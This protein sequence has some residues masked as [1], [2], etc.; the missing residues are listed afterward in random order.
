MLTNAGPY[1]FPSR[2][3]QIY[4]G[5][6]WRTQ[7]GKRK[8]PSWGTRT[9]FCRAP[10]SAANTIVSGERGWSA[11]GAPVALIDNVG[12]PEHE[13]IET[14]F[15][16][17]R[18]THL[19]GVGVKETSYY[20][21][22]A[23]LLNT[24]G[25]KLKPRVRCIIH[26]HSIGAGLPD[27]AL[28]TTDQKSSAED[29]LADGLVPSRGVVEIKSPEADA[30]ATAN[31]EQVKKYVAKYGLVLVSNLREFII[32]GR[33]DGQPRQLEKFSIAES[34]SDFWKL[35]ASPKTLYDSIGVTFHEY[36]IRVL[37]HAAPLAAPREVAWFLA[38]YARDAKARI[39]TRADLPG[40]ASLRSA[41]EEALGLKFAGKDGEHFFR[42]SLVQT[43]FY[44]VFSAWVLWS[45]RPT[46]GPKNK[47][48]W[49]EAAWSLHVPMIRT[50]FDQLAT[51]TKLQSL[52]LEEV[53][54]WTQTA[55]NR[56]D[57]VAFFSNFEEHHA[58]QYFYEP[59]LAAYDPVLRKRLGVWFTPPEIVRYMVSRIDQV[60]RHDLDVH[61]GFADPNVFVLDPCCGTGAFLVEVL[62]HIE[63]SLKASGGDALT[64]ED[65]KTAAI[66]RVFGFELLPAPFVVSHLQLGLLLQT[67]GAPL[68]HKLNERVGVYLTNALTGWN[69]PQG[70]K[71]K[72]VFPEMEEERDA[73]ELVKREKTILVV[74]GNPPY[75][76]FAGVSP[77]EEQ[78][79][80]EPYKKGLS[81]EW[82]IKKYNLDELYVRFLRLGERRIANLTKKG[83]VCYISSYSYLSDPSFVVLR[84]RFCDEFD[85]IW[86]DCLNGDSR[87]TGKQT[88]DG[89]PD[90]SVFSTEY[91]REGIRLGTSVGLFA[92]KDS[93]GTAAV[94]YREFW[95]A[96]KRSLLLKTL[97]FAEDFDKQYKTVNPVPQNRFSFRPT[98]TEGHYAEWPTVVEFAEEE[99][100]SGL[101][102][103]RRGALM[104]HDR[105]VLEERMSRYYD[106]SLA[107]EAFAS[108]GSGL[109]SEAARFNA[110]ATRSKVLKTETFQNDQ[111]RRYTLFPLDG[112]WCYYSTIRPLWNEPRPELVSQAPKGEPFFVVR[113][114]AERANEGRPAL[115]TSGLPDRHLLRSHAVGIPLRLNVLPPA[116]T[117]DVAQVSMFAVPDDG[118]KTTANLSKKT[119][120]Y[121]SSLTSTNVDRDDE[122]SRA[123]WFHSL[124][125]IYAP[126]YLSEHADA[127]SGDWPRIPLPDSLSV[128]QKSAELGR[129]VAQLVDVEKIVLGVVGGKLRKEIAV[130]GRITGP[131]GLSLSITAGWGHYHEKKQIV[132]PGRGVQKHREFNSEEKTAIEEGTA[133][134]GISKDDWLALWGGDT[135]DIYLNNEAHWSNVPHAV[136]NYTI[137]G[138]QV[139]KKWLSY[140][141]EE[142]L[143][144]PITKEEAREFTHLVRRIGALVLLEPELNKAY[145]AVKSA[146]YAWSQESPAIGGDIGTS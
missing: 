10:I 52:G 70:A 93:D 123:V 139:L 143:G 48:N 80:V 117:S 89:Q 72:L 44:G 64:A 5:S 115:I 63:R 57:R 129:V 40:L 28:I 29:P 111:I 85:Y 53:L 131:K 109:T 97:D 16:D 68:S 94:R 78:G 113:R 104:A 107:W 134:F 75:Y 127:I 128:L 102:E 86:I 121:L 41:L 105:S 9:H 141:E 19:S 2:K 140:R 20:P 74:L 99:P 42:S 91:N 146:F 49:H 96:D 13:F 34:A 83:I 126:L 54:D 61:D 14:F 35:T 144:R 18:D 81:K 51:P 45:K 22:L 98:K 58:V 69:P 136:W 46:T 106:I 37:L 50:L 43:L 32:V 31:S 92:K 62:L 90:P 7:G 6:T 135:L 56:V 133:E 101:E 65:V 36:L 38:S 79:L 26:P 114:Y 12:L 124:A 47:F 137:G 119:R 33:V 100:I 4:F 23:N 71:Q 27:G 3:K 77:E 125:L 67:I 11:R 21:Y 87:E 118:A 84:K 132:M 66:E 8:A 15:T 1:A 138:Y 25:K 17:L 110:S 59:F 76:A 103:N 122:L 30:S 108:S 145:L 55:L 112:R 60:L 142:V 120:A 130:L 39:D 88:P 116:G 24:L 95:G 82:N 73:A